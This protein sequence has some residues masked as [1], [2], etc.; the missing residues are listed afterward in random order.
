MIFQFLLDFYK[1]VYD[2]F[3]KDTLLNNAENFNFDD[4]YDSEKK[5]K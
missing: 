3:T 1:I 4:I 5:E 2:W